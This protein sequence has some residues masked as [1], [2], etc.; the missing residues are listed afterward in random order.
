MHDSEPTVELTFGLFRLQLGKF[1]D[2]RETRRRSTN[3]PETFTD[4]IHKDISR[5][6]IRIESFM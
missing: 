3:R 5:I 6:Q 4:R 1:T 2:I